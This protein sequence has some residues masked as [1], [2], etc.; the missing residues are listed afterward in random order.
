[1]PSSDYAQTVVKVKV[2]A[3]RQTKKLPKILPSIQSIKTTFL[4]DNFQYICFFKVTAF[5]I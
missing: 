4:L 5:I 2:I 3:I 1:M